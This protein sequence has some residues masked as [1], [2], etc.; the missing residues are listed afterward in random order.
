MLVGEAG[1]TLHAG[2]REPF[3]YD[4]VLA[5]GRHRYGAVLDAVGATECWATSVRA[6]K[7]P[8][9]LMGSRFSP[10][11]SWHS[12]IRGRTIRL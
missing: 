4:Q 11:S 8:V 6:W 12:R 5:D 2:H 9:S 3:D 10:R 7:A 1:D